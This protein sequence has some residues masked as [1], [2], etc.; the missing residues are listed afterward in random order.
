VLDFGR[1][2]TYRFFGIDGR[3]GGQSLVGTIVVERPAYVHSFGMTERYLIL[4][5]VPLVV[6]PLRLRFSGKPFIRNYEWEPD[7][8]VRFHLLEKASGRVVRTGRAPAFF[9]FH[10]VNAFEDGNDVVATW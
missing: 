9:A 5:E 1:R 3:T 2:S 10:H 6:N 8:G 4:A 7:R